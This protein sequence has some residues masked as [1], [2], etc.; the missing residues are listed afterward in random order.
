MQVL[1]RFLMANGSLPIPKQVLAL[2]AA[3]GIGSGATGGYT[4]YRTHQRDSMMVTPV[5]V[6]RLIADA[7]SKHLD[8]LREIETDV[9]RIQTDVEWIRRQLAEGR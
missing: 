6:Q 9:A 3:A 5:E 1:W 2:L 8:R 4:S 7:E